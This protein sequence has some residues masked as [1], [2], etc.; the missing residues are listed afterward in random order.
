MCFKQR[1]NQTISVLILCLCIWIAPPLNAE[2]L[3]K[4]RRQFTC[5]WKTYDISHTEKIALYGAKRRHFLTDTLYWG[6]AGYGAITGKRSGYLEG[7]LILGS[8]QTMR[9]SWI[10]DVRLFFGAGGGGAAPQGGGM[11]I[12]PT[13]GI[14]HWLSHSSSLILELGY[15]TFLNGDIKSMTLGVTYNWNYWELFTQ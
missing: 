10:S 4:Y 8:Q 6:E 2:A 14:G 7:G 13:I 12:H 9:D 1:Q 3:H 15:I 5:E 11:I